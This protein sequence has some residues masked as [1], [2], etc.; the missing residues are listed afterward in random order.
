M[1]I[2]GDDT[3]RQMLQDYEIAEIPF[4]NLEITSREKFLK[5]YID[6][7]GLVG[8]E[9]DSRAWWATD[10]ASKNRS[11]SPLPFLLHEFFAIIESITEAGGKDLFVVNPSW[12]LVDSLR[13]HLS[14]QDLDYQHLPDPFV[15]WREMVTTRIRMICQ[16]FSVLLK[17]SA[18]RFYFNFKLKERIKELS[19]EKIYYVIKTFLYDHSFDGNGRYRDTFFGMLPG[20]LEQKKDVLILADV[21]GNCRT[22]TEKIRKCQSHLILPF[23]IFLTLGS[24]IQAAIE[25]LS[26]KIRIK[27]R[28]FF[29]GYD[30]SEIINLELA[31]TFN[32]IPFYQFIR[33]W[34][35]K[36]LL[37]SI[38]VG[39]FLLT[40]ENNAWEKMSMLAVR[41]HS[42]D[43]T[44]VGYQH[45]VV[46]QASANAF[47]SQ[48]EADIIP[49]PDRILTVG[50]IPKEIM[51]RYGSF[52]N[53][54]I[55]PACG[56]RFEYLFKGLKRERR[57]N[58]HILLALEGL[59]GA[60]KL[61]NYAL[62]ELGGNKNY[63][64]RIRT[65]PEMPCESFENKLTHRLNAVSNF[66]QT[67]NVLLKD[68][69]EWADVVMYWGS[70]VS[71]EALIMGIPIIRYNMDTVLDYDPLFE[72]KHLKWVVSDKTAL[73][74]TLEDVYELNDDRFEKARVQAKQYLADYFFPV[75]EERLGLFLPEEKR[76]TING[77]SQEKAQG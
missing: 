36:N 30:V 20:Y 53:G 76:G 16:I 17:V 25:T 8:R 18:R 59:D 49:M 69:L 35:T 42:P 10:M 67:K 33:Y 27:R 3:D 1:L 13:L 19:K 21:F 68:D 54:K 51:E 77:L 40:Y 44:I 75:T 43:T 29:F 62:K 2:N 5:E 15:K 63:Q 64:I 46:P 60:H 73:V 34:M 71:L 12:V 48:N 7:I 31:R 38:R 14:K 47:I 32:G 70:T 9:C 24:G 57:K 28:Y 41:E 74:N 72:C 50:E 66:T 22:N 6:L 4:K 52:D 58:G 23:E 26:T 39:T 65:H 45:S 61:V 55:E 11:T 56:L 37:R